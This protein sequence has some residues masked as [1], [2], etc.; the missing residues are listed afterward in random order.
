MTEK[1]EGIGGFWVIIKGTAAKGRV[2]IR[3][4]KGRGGV[5]EAVDCIAKILVHLT[6]FF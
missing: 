4:G 3:E 2:V 6:F 1:E 5:R